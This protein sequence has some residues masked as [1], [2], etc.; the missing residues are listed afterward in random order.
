MPLRRAGIPR[1]LALGLALFF[2]GMPVCVAGLCNP[3]DQ[4]FGSLPP[5]PPWFDQDIGSMGGCAEY[6]SSSGTFTVK[7]VGGFIPLTTSDSLHFAY[8]AFTGDFEFIARLTGLGAGTQDN[9]AGLMVRE[10]GA[11]S[12]RH[13][14][15][16]EQERAVR[17]RKCNGPLEGLHGRE[18]S[19]RGLSAHGNPRNPSLPKAGA[20]PGPDHLL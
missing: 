18:G 14:D 13:A 3:P 12:S 8:R 19:R 16:Y 10:S 9:F 17:R 7:S 20:V 11:S 6:N 15:V 4:G 5:S 2:I 1:N